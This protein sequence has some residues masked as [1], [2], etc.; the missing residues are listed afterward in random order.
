MKPSARHQINCLIFALRLWR[1]HGGYLMI[2]WSRFL[3]GVPHFLWAP[4][5]A[6]TGNKRIRHYVPV[7]PVRN[8]WA[9]SAALRF[10]GRVKNCDDRK[11]AP[12]CETKN[13]CDYRNK[14]DYDPDA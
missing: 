3:V 5:D 8:R 14:R 1:R 11:C 4:D 10:Q 13:E 9:W 6:L 7:K 2:R 12:D